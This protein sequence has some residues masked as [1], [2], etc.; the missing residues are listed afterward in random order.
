MNKITFL[1]TGAADWNMVADFYEP[2]FR[3]FT[4]VM[5]DDKILADCSAGAIIYRDKT[6]NE[7]L[8]KSIDTIVITH[9]HSDHFSPAAIKIVASESQKKITV[10]AH[11][12]LHKYLEDV[13][14]INVCDI[15]AYTSFSSGKYEITPLVANHNASLDGELPFHYLVKCGRKSVF[16]GFDGGWLTAD[17]WTYLRN[18][19]ITLYIADATH[20]YGYESNF[21]NFYHNS[22]EMLDIMWKTFLENGV[23]D[24][25]S[26]MILTHLSKSMHPSH[27]VLQS[28]LKSKGYIVAYDGMVTEY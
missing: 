24:K 26:K 10:Y 16:I 2:G 13:T 15:R 22:I 4:S 23:C 1:G 3:A 7:N 27:K 28:R 9:S 11:K 12:T 14:G 18:E 25:S 21:R 17:T 5:I 20:G 19:K 8:F 6:H